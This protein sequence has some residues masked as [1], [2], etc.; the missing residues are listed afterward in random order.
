MK[1]N[2]RKLL[3]LV[4]T[5]AML[6]SVFAA[7]EDIGQEIDLGGEIVIEGGLEGE[8]QGESGN[9]TSSWARARKANRRSSWTRALTRRTETWSWRWARTLTST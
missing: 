6:L 3:A 9:R 4:M 8:T 1:R 2:A 7:A 5:L